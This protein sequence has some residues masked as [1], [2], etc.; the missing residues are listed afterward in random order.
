MLFSG[1][2]SASGQKYHHLLKYAKP[3]LWVTVFLTSNRRKQ[4]I[5]A[6][7]AASRFAKGLAF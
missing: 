3:P 6:C 4:G 7:P 5:A 2:F 1:D